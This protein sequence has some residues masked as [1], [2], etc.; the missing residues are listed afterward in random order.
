MRA[1]H[2]C[3]PTFARHET[4]QPRYGWIKKA[5][6]AASDDADV[7]NQ[8]DA[9]VRLG[10]GKNMVKSIRFWGLAFRVM[11]ERPAVERRGSLV[12]PTKFGRAVFADDGWDPY[13][14]LPGTTWLLHWSLLKPGS[15]TPVWWLAFNEFS[16]IEF[17][18]EELE[19]F[20]VDRVREW[21]GTN[22]PAVKKDVLC[23]LRMYAD[24]HAYRA[25]FEDRI[26]APFRELKL[27]QPSS[28]TP[29]AFRFL[30]GPKPT[31]PPA[32]AAFACLDFVARTESTSRVISINRLATEPGS[33]GQVFKMTESDLAALLSRAAAESPDIEVT[34]AAGVAQLAFD[35]DPY[36]V[37]T[38]VLRD[39]YQRITGRAGYF[40]IQ[41]VGGWRADHA[42][43]SN[44]EE[45]IAS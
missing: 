44:H 40:G 21:S 11:T 10:V 32:I 6:D 26:D 31:L 12:V 3:L 13:C 17:T 22:A 45:A 28:T 41:W 8:P 43:Q 39:H 7:F 19:Q 38:E 9:V 30:I 36:A 24:G 35:D 2:A 16:G 4:F 42:A 1:E 5:I 29:G 20:V 27:I 37:A 33:P 25:S 15:M 34:S 18:P 23:M 14:E